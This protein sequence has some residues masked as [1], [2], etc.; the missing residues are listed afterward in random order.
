[1]DEDVLVPE[2]IER[3]L[4]VVD[5]VLVYTQDT[6]RLKKRLVYN[7]KRCNGCGVCVRVCPTGALELGPIPEIATGL[8]VPPIT[9]DI[10]KCTFCGMCAGLCPIGAIEMHT[11]DEE[12]ESITQSLLEMDVHMNER[13][14]PCLLCERSCPNDAI[15][16]SLNIPRK[17]ELVPFEEDAE[18]TI[19]IDREKCTLC[20]L[21]AHFCDALLMV[22]REPDVNAPCPFEDVLVDEERCD[23]C[24]LCVGLCPE[25]A[26]EVVRTKGSEV[27]AAP[28]PIEG[29]VEVDA[30][31]CTRAGWCKAVCPYDAVE[32]TRPFEGTIRLLRGPL[33]EC[34]PVGCHACFNV[35]PS[36]CFYV[37]APED[38]EHGG[39]EGI[40]IGVRSEYC[41]YCGA[42]E[43][44]CPLDGIVVER[45]EVRHHPLPEGAWHEQWGGA[46]ES[47][48]GPSR[49]RPELKKTI[50]RVV[51]ELPTPDHGLEHV[52]EKYLDEVRETLRTLEERLRDPKVRRRMEMR[53]GI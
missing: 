2:D 12:G 10:D 15:T 45:S 34:D 14:L 37:K 38:T 7:Y 39:V 16:L 46:V 3:A 19:E 48:K 51:Y 21:C 24:T 32:L 11:L 33:L 20:G 27:K 47:L 31:L 49:R 1:M 17:E 8:D 50:E 4:D 44:A 42:C 35:C 26:I 29:K 18:G 53:E 5:D 9:W 30:K 40:R 13:C 36:E 41:I 25:D 43:H 6:P 22:E 23:Y 28:P 52:P